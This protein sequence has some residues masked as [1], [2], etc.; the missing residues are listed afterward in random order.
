MGSALRRSQGA[1]RGDEEQNLRIPLHHR[2][3]G[4]WTSDRSAFPSHGKAPQS[5][6]TRSSTAAEPGELSKVQAGKLL[7]KSSP[8]LH[9]RRKP[10]S[11]DSPPNTG[12]LL[13]V[14]GTVKAKGVL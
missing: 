8:A 3:L 1:F 2:G 14:L 7:P 6:S 4:T 11:P 5:M 10:V 9:P 12:L 13:G